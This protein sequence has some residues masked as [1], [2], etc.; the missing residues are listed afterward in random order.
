MGSQLSEF[1]GVIFGCVCLLLVALTLFPGGTAL[2]HLIAFGIVGASVYWVSPISFRP[3]F[4]IAICVTALWITLKLWSLLAIGLSIYCLMASIFIAKRWLRFLL[5][6]G[7]CISVPLAY[8]WI[9]HSQEQILV[10]G[11]IGSIASFRP[12]LLGWANSKGDWRTRLSYLIPFPSA[13]LPLFPIIRPEQGVTLPMAGRRA[14]PQHLMTA[15]GTMF[16]GVVQLLLY[17]YLLRNLA[18]GPQYVISLGDLSQ[19]IAVGFLLYLKVSGSFHVALGLL[20]FW[21]YSLPLSHDRYLLASSPLDFWRRINIYWKTFVEMIVFRPVFSLLYRIENLSVRISLATIAVFVATIVLHSYQWWMLKG[22]WS[23]RSTDVLFWTILG[24]ATI[25]GATVW[26]I[27]KV[28][29]KYKFLS[30]TVNMACLFLLWSLWNEPS[31]SAWI[32]LFIGL[33]FK[34]EWR[35]LWLGLPLA[36]GALSVSTKY[37]KSLEGWLSFNNPKGIIAATGL[38]IF[39]VLVSYPKYFPLIELPQSVQRLTNLQD[40]Q[41]D[42]ERLIGGYYEGLQWAPFEKPARWRGRQPFVELPLVRENQTLLGFELMPNVQF[43]F[44]D[45][46]MSTNHHGFLDQNYEKN[47]PQGTIRIAL[48]GSS[49]SAGF[50]VSPRM[51]YEAVVE[52]SLNSSNLQVEIL[53]FSLPQVSLLDYP[54]L[55]KR[56]LDFDIDLVMIEGSF[57]DFIRTGHA[58]SDKIRRHNSLI[59]PLLDKLDPQFSEEDFRHD[60]INAKPLVLYS[61]NTL[62][63]TCR[64][65]KVECRYSFIPFPYE[66]PP[67]LREN[68][69]KLATIAGLDIIDVEG[70]FSGMDLDRLTLGPKDFHPNEKGH[71]I[72]A[73]ALERPLRELIQNLRENPQ[74]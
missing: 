66:Y 72:I 27:K 7:P 32:N 25:I 46:V 15:L 40:A 30:V 11:V 56:A 22:E 54:D 5:V 45:A 74:P 17:R 2:S 61:M 23:L 29:S 52:R 37:L 35:L 70:A 58:P 65:R 39:C 60:L 4:L 44:A 28:S 9:G 24:L 50:G 26:P 59:K 1:G 42:Q 53:N 47:K 69:V 64:E 13:G 18:F 55:L 8:E 6:L 3:Y 48:L 33:E 10:C 49:I 68:L 14:S 63:E 34:G 12:L 21:G 71:E 62:A 67:R 38:S 73:H 41:L 31:L 57:A 19:Y 16:Q 51:R 20:N 43:N 36:L